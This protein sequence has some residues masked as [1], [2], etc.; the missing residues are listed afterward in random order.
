M[1]TID[2]I[3]M[4]PTKVWVSRS[5]PSAVRLLAGVSH[6]LKLPIAEMNLDGF[7]ESDE[8]PFFKHKVRTIVIHSLDPENK[9]VLHSARDNFSAI[10]F[11]DYI[12]TYQ[13]L[14]GYLAVANVR[15]RPESPTDS[16]ST[17]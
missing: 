5:D 8:E 10:S 1:L 13:L 6:S 7:G 2:S 12:D 3:G 16:A 17:N 14:A 11:K 9:G 4:G 15:L